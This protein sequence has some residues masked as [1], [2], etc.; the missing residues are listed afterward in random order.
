MFIGHAEQIN[1]LVF[2]TDYLSLISIGE[3]I[4]LWDFVAHKKDQTEL[5][6]VINT[7]TFGSCVSSSLERGC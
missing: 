2:T 7:K 3:A 5:E 6:Y 4:F 1:Q